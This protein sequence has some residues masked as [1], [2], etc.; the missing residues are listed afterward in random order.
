V[1]ITIGMDPNIVTLGPLVI[2]W[3]AIAI[4]VAI[5]AAVQV[6]RLEFVRKHISF[7]HWD[8]MVYWTVAGGIVGARVFYL[9]DH[10]GY[11]LH[12]PLESLALNEG[13]L[14]VYGA[15]FGGFLTV[16]ALT[17]IYRLPPLP[18]IDAIAPGLILAQAF[19]RIGC[20]I[21]GD[22]WGAPTSSP[23]AF[24]YTNPKDLLP[25]DLLGVPT[26]PYPF[27]DLLIN[28]AIFAVVWRLRRRGLPHGALFALFTALYGASR[29]LIS[30]MRQERVWFW[31][32]QEAQVV[33]LAALIASLIALALL[34]WRAPE[35][36]RR[37]DLPAAV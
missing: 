24:V 11:F 8:G 13:G 3:H 29:F 21:N 28:L 12:H 22:A 17:R 15:V 5:I 36:Q 34:F 2:A 1:L 27:Y 23:F 33:A 7:D 30:F 20:I 18:V 16:L 31:G 35:R 4:L 6:T 25:P 10:A 9:I 32:L 14:A 19:G 37:Q 26:G